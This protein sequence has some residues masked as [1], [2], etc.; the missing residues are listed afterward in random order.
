MSDEPNTPTPAPA[1]AP[2]PEE[3]FILT[4]AS[5]RPVVAPDPAPV[6]APKADAKAEDEGDVPEWMRKRLA[7]SKRQRDD[8]LAKVDEFDVKLKEVTT[9]A[10]KAL[11]RAGMKE[12]D[13]AKFD[14]YEDYT[15]AKRTYDATMA[16]KLEIPKEVK[17]AAP[18]EADEALADVR[19]AV[20]AVDPELWKT[21]VTM[22]NEAAAK[23]EPLFFS[24]L[25]MVEVADSEEPVTLFKAILAMPEDERK[26]LAGLGRRALRRELREMAK[27][28]P[29]PTPAAPA[30]DPKTGQFVK[31]QSDAP[32]PPE[33]LRAPAAGP[34]PVSDP[35]IPLSEFFSR[36][37]AEERTRA[38]GW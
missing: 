13:A 6:E 20:E 32:P 21:A 22:A 7:R 34:R 38:T 26:E 12:P 2:A 17:P 18:S 9:L 37:D 24:D 23:K 27:A 15:K 4:D 35:N 30:K 10:E 29:A 5:V 14:S 28:A 16:E 11:A 19:E 1:P 33:P 25:M 31:R 8:A 36:R 3:K